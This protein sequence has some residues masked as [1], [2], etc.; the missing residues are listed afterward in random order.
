MYTLRTGAE[1]EDA[2]M[3]EAADL[4]LRTR[5]WNQFMGTHETPEQVALRDPLEFE[6]LVAIQKGLMPPVEK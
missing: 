2:E 6:M 4:M 1:M 5:M 3:P